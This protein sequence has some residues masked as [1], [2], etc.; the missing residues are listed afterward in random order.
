MIRLTPR[1]TESAQISDFLRADFRFFVD[2]L[3][4]AVVFLVLSAAGFFLPLLPL[5]LPELAVSSLL[6]P[7]TRLIAGLTFY[8]LVC[9][10][11]YP[12]ISITIL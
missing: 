3:T 8:P 1:L 6:H 2:F 7:F 4:R 10:S 12:D 9:C 5:F 11:M